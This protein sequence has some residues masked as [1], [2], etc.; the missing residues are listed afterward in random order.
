MGQTTTA[1]N[2]RGHGQLIM[3]AY[4][5]H[6]YEQFEY[7][8]ILTG[9]E[10]RDL[11]N[12]AE[13]FWIAVFETT[14]PNGYNLEPGG[15]KFQTWDDARRKRHGDI[16]RGKPH[17]RPLGARSG[18]KGKAFPEA[19]KE[20]LRQIMLTRPSPN[21][22]RKASEETRAK[23]SA[24]Q[25]ARFERDGSPNTGR[26]HSAET[27]AKMSASHSGRVQ[28][29]DERA[30]RSAAITEWHKRRKEEALKCQH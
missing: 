17:P 6:G 30:K 27:R 24:A 10:D 23:M 26:R 22:G 7:D 25:K 16:R 4:K 8:R 13:R 11:L 5:K 3:A 1:R 14:N 28:S 18:M 15:A 19:G 9:I 29:D 21:V 2:K 20:K 12:W